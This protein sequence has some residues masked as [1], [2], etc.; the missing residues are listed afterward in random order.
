MAFPSHIADGSDGRWAGA[1]GRHGQMTGMVGRSRLSWPTSSAALA[2]TEVKFLHGGESGPV[3]CPCS[4]P[5]WRAWRGFAWPPRN[6]LYNIQKTSGGM[7]GPD[8]P[9][10]SRHEMVLADGGPQPR[11]R[12]TS[13][14]GPTATRKP[15]SR[16]RDQD[17]H[18]RH[19]TSRNDQTLRAR[20]G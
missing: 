15:A 3:A 13:T 8:A 12:R 1:N 6:G 9:N 18:R 14:P 4:A 17:K 10:G 5:G 16:P 2:A 20:R 19:R 7:T 11:H